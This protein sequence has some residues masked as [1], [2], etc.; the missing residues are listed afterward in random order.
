MADAVEAISS[1]LKDLSLSLKNWLK[2]FSVNTKLSDYGSTTYIAVL[3]YMLL[4][5]F[6]AFVLT[7]NTGIQ[8]FS[9]GL[10][11]ALFELQVWLQT[12]VVKLML[13]YG[14]FILGLLIA[15]KSRMD[16]AYDWGLFSP[17]VRLL[18]VVYI[19]N[20]TCLLFTGQKDPEY[21][22]GPAGQPGGIFTLTKNKSLYVPV[23]WLQTVTDIFIQQIVPGMF[24]G[25][26]VGKVVVG[27]QGGFA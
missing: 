12:V 27:I 23:L 18:I 4:L 15:S 21:T 6:L 24:Y 25:Y 1:P 2:Q 19:L 11:Q 16:F 26:A 13:Y 14:A 20:K 22:L 9:K 17:F 5:H 8:K 7:N 3:L 10:S